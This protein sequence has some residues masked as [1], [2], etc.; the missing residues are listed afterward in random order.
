[1]ELDKT[2]SGLWNEGRRSTVCERDQ[3]RCARVAASMQ[4]SSSV[5]K[6]LIMNGSLSYNWRT[7]KRECCKMRSKSETRWGLIGRGKIDESPMLA[8]PEKKLKLLRPPSSCTVSSLHWC[9]SELMCFFFYRKD[10][11]CSV[12]HPKKIQMEETYIKSSICTCTVQLAWRVS[13]ECVRSIGNRV[14]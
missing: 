1:M 4:Y 2:S 13:W 8:K 3:L 9:F 7:L 14:N 5:R 12:Y 10:Q 6:R 11:S